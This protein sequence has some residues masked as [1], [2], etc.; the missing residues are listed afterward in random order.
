MSNQA[1]KGIDEIPVFE[2]NIETN[3]FLVFGEKIDN[4][5]SIESFA[6]FLNNIRNELSELRH[7]KKVTESMALTKQNRRLQKENKMFRNSLEEIREYVNHSDFMDWHL[8]V[9]EAE[10]RKKDILEIIDKSLGDNNE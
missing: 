6:I 1:I 5:N 10:L 7:Y 8:G 4:V 9:S 2:M 3:E